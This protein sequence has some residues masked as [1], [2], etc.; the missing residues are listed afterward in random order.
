MGD[1]LASD[2]MTDERNN[3]SLTTAMSLSS[4]CPINF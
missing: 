2:A 1:L 3:D 4:L